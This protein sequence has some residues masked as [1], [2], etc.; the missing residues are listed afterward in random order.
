MNEAAMIAPSETPNAPATRRLELEK[1][2][3]EIWKTAATT[4]NETELVQSLLNKAGPIMGCQNIAFMPYDEN[5][6]EIAV[7]QQWRADGQT[8]GLG[9]IVPR[10]IFKRFLGQPYIQISFDK[11]PG[12]LQPILNIF[13]RKYG[14]R[15]SLVVAYGDP[16]RPDGYIAVNNFTR[17]RE[18]TPTEVDL[19]I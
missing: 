13:Q 7:R 11:L 17:A 18:Y 12:W 16:A 9:D 14:T 6:R 8:A 1:L 3:A 15:S 5:Q 4:E 2:R 10:W 19:F